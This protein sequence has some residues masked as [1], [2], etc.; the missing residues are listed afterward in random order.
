DERGGGHRQEAD[1]GEGDEEA[2]EGAE[3]VRHGRVLSVILRG[4]GVWPPTA[5]VCARDAP[6]AMTSGHRTGT[7]DPPFAPPSPRWARGPVA[8]CYAGRIVAQPRSSAAAT[9]RWEAA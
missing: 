9:G 7:V 4:P 1:E 5:P 3:R 2:G 6:R 8:V